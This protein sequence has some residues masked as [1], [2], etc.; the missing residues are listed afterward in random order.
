MLKYTDKNRVPYVC[1]IVKE[2]GK[3]ARNNYLEFTEESF[4]FASHERERKKTNFVLLS[5]FFVLNLANNCLL[6]HSN[7]KERFV[8]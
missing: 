5:L 6:F 4:M 3:F 7:A 2:T 8:L 1:T